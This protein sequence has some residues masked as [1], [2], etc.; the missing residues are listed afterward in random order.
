[1]R[2]ILLETSQDPI[3]LEVLFGFW[4]DILLLMLK[5]A[6]LVENNDILSLGQSLFLTMGD[7]H[8]SASLDNLYKM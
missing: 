3:T 4:Q 6:L 2:D 7:F 1:M 8:L 5:M